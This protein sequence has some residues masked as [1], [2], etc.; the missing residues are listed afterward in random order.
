MIAKE[1]TK[2]KKLSLTFCSAKKFPSFFKDLS[3]ANFVLVT[4]ITQMN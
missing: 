3:Y 1:G 2:K 4:S